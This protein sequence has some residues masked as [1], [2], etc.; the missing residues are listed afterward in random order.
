M[1]KPPPIAGIL[2][3]G[4]PARPGRDRWGMGESGSHAGLPYTFSRNRCLAN[5]MSGAFKIRAFASSWGAG[6][7]G[8]QGG[9]GRWGAVCS[10][11]SSWCSPSMD[12]W[13]LAASCSTEAAGLQPLPPDRASLQWSFGPQASRPQ[14]PLHSPSTCACS[15]RQGLPGVGGPVCLRP[16]RSPPG[17]ALPSRTVSARP[18][19]PRGAR[20][21]AAPAPRTS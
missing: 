3:S 5:K 10:S 21:T 12:A 7:G 4:C 1:L 8:V 11:S 2:Q 13:V 17:S 14:A 16:H 20:G 9:E 18:C 15:L 19:H 6:G